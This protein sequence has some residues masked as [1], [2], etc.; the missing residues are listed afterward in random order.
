MGKFVLD[1]GAGMSRPT[2]FKL[3]PSDGAESVFRAAD[4]MQHKLGHINIRSKCSSGTA[5]VLVTEKVGEESGRPTSLASFLMRDPSSTLPFLPGIV[6]D[7]CSQTDRLGTESPDE[8]PIASILWSWHDLERIRNQYE[9]HSCPP[10]ALDP[11]LFSDPAE[12]YD[13]LRLQQTPIRLARQSCIHGDLNITNIALDV[14]AKVVRGYIFDAAAFGGG[15]SGWDLATLEVT[16]LLHS[17]GSLDEGLVEYCGSFYNQALPAD[18]GFVRED[19]TSRQ[20]NS[21]SLVYEIR[22]RVLERV[23]PEV[24]ALMVFDNALMQLGGLD[25][26]VSRNKITLPSDAALLAA[27]AAGWLIRVSPQW[28]AK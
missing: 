1:D 26:Q 6:D 28:F 10:P 22:Q 5:A 23:S 27:L 7:V 4:V 21:A 25:F 12:V 18:L 13:T 15:F 11:T 8:L 14:G 16:T 2:F 3:W 17:V 19:A 24:Y 9:K 20:R